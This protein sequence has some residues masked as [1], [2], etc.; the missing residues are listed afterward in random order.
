MNV[1]S[2]TII[3]LALVFA[4]EQ[5]QTLLCVRAAAL[6]EAVREIPAE[7]STTVELRSALPAP[8][9]ASI[10]TRLERL[11]LLDGTPPVACLRQLRVSL[12]VDE[13]GRRP[14]AR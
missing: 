11:L 9:S 7:Q 5:I 4:P 12:S 10:P 1:A 13:G 2:E 6:I 14:A 3:M 8:G